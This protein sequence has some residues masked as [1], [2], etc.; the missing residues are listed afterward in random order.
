MKSL[1]FNLVDLV[2]NEN[3]QEALRWCRHRRRDWPVADE[4]WA[5]SL[6]W[7]R[8]EQT[9]LTALFSGTYH[10]EPVKVLKKDSGTIS[11]IWHARD[12]IVLKALALAILPR[13]EDF[14]S[15]HCTHVKGH[16]S[17]PKAIK[18]VTSASRDYAYVFKSDVKSFYESIN[19]T[20]MLQQLSQISSCPL[21]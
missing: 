18:S 16:G 2:T 21:F 8:E 10:F 14:L 4:I 15:K 6:N 5:I 9:I 13:I 7:Q 3:L 11:W 20:I 19:H 12:A 17:I 1:A